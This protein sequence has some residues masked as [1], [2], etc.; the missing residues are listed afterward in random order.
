MEVKYASDSDIAC[1]KKLNDIVKFDDQIISIAMK[2]VSRFK[3]LLLDTTNTVANKTAPAPR[4]WKRVPSHLCAAM[5]FIIALALSSMH[6]LKWFSKKSTFWNT[7]MVDAPSTP[8]ERVNV[9]R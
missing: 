8:V 2:P 3:E 4:T 5:K 9:E 1:E 7:L 6:F